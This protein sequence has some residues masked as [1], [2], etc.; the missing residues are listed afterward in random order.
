MYVIFLIQYSIIFFCDILIVSEV[1]E[2]K[3]VIAL[4]G[5]ISFIAFIVYANIA[6]YHSKKV[7]VTQKE[8]EEL[9]DEIRTW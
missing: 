6:S 2:V 8:R 3:N 5:L 9:E 7:N 4:V 1:C